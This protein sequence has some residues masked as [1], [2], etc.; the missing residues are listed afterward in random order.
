MATRY[1]GACG[2]LVVGTLLTTLVLDMGQ[3][4]NEEV[5]P[6]HIPYILHGALV[7]CCFSRAKIL[8]FSNHACGRMI[9]SSVMIST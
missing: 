7:G 2:W 6:V 3:E 4:Y 9:V 8:N 5:F 1:V